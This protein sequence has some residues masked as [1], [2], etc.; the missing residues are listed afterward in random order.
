MVIATTLSPSGNNMV[1]WM[2]NTFSS[3]L[4][5]TNCRIQSPCWVHLIIFTTKPNTHTFT[6]SKLFFVDGY[7][8][9][10]QYH[11][12][13]IPTSTDSMLKYTLI[14]CSHCYFNVTFVYTVTGLDLSK[15]GT[16]VDLLCFIFHYFCP[17]LFL[18]NGFLVFLPCF[19]VN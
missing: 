18:C 6:G 1:Y 17:N 9:I 5:S 12:V 2:T 15:C 7:V 8:H 16:K 10:L 11:I 3:T 14:L 19:G 4:S 13:S